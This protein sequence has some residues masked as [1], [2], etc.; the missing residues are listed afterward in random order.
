MRQSSSKSEQFSIAFLGL[1]FDCI[2]PGTK[3]IA[4][5]LILLVFFVAMVLLLKIYVVPIIGGVW[6]KGF[7][8]LIGSKIGFLSQLKSSRS[9]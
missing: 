9:P 7:I 8:K 3:T 2:N 1:K 4:I 5:L 6:G